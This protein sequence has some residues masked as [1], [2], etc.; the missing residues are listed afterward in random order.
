M[1]MRC[2][3]AALAQDTVEALRAMPSAVHELISDP[4]MDKQMAKLGYPVERKLSAGPKGFIDLDKSW[5]LIHF[6]LSGSAWG[7]EL[8]AG[9]LM[10]GEE[11]GEDLGYGPPR[12]LM[13]EQVAEVAAFLDG[14]DFVDSYNDVATQLYTQKIYPVFREDDITLELFHFA[15]AFFG[16][17]RPF[18]QKASAE[19]N[20]VLVAIT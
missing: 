20:A 18:M 9:F 15:N 3:L 10:S 8:P 12:I 16:E 17:L 11:I 19:K 7:A 14:V 13:P 6:A 1:G 5:H 2:K 4:A